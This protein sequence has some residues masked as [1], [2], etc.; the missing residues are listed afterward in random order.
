MSF[1]VKFVIILDRMFPLFIKRFAAVSMSRVAYYLLQKHKLI[2]VHNLTRSFPEKPLNEILQI[3][4][5]T[6]ANFALTFIEFLQILYLNRDN[7]HRWVSVKG[8][9]HYEKA[10]NEG[11]GVLLFTAHFGNW[12]MG[13]AALAIL[14]KPP[15]FMARVLDSPFLEEITTCVRSRLGIGNIHKKNVMTSILSQLRKGEV[16][17]LL[18]DQNAAAREGVFVNFFGRPACATTGIALM[19]MHTGAAV[20]PVFTTR[21]PDG[22]YLTEIGPQVET[23]NTGNRDQDVLQNTQNYNTIIENHVRQYPGQW[24]WLHQRW[25][26][27]LVQARRI[28]S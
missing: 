8:L 11:K 4:K 13:N 23:V 5:D 10:C 25:K 7:L 16:L 6:Y 28:K 14:S 12:E 19:A 3:V 15:I 18:I 27:K 20:L 1:P 21:M 2:A 22:R 9:E 26:T 24:L 17:K